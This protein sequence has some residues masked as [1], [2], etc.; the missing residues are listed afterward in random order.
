MHMTNLF[1]FAAF[2]AAALFAWL[3][4][5]LRGNKNPYARWIGT[6]LTALVAL[7]LGLIGVTASAGLYKERYSRRAPVPPLQVEG[8]AEQIRRGQ[9]IADAFCAACH[10]PSGTLTGG[11]D[12]GKHLPLDMGSFVSSNLTASGALKH[13]SDGQIFRAIRNSIDADGY[14]LIIMSLTNAGRLSDDDVRALIA[15]I[16]SLPPAGAA[17]PDPPDQ[18]N[19]V[20]LL[21]L[22]SGQLPSGKPVSTTAILAPPKAETIAYGEYILSYQDCRECHGQQLTGGIQGQWAP[23]GPGLGL[24]ADW[25]RGQFIATLRTGTDPSGHELGERM[26]WR[27]LG[28]MDDVELG[29]VYEYLAHRPD[30]GNTDAK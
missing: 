17:T 9:G 5:R 22:G 3:S 1:V 21:L 13:W 16:R 14:R 12:I 15:Y 19:L 23:V 6:G 30:T 25:T 24:V 4:L 10:S 11:E 28:R 2:I 27:P 26:P 18:L 7:A 8:S 29:A 20:G